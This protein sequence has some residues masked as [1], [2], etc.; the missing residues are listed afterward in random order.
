MRGP[1]TDPQNNSHLLLQGHPEEGR[2]ILGDSHVN[3]SQSHDLLLR[4]ALITQ[5]GGE[6]IQ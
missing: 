4:K 6:N 2:P 1:N 5:P 3:V